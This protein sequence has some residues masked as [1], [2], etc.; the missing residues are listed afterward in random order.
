MTT[1][2]LYKHVRSDACSPRAFLPPWLARHCP[3][4]SPDC[5]HKKN[6]SSNKQPPQPPSPCLPPHTISLSTAGFLSF[7]PHR[8][9]QRIFCVALLLGFLF[10]SSPRLPLQLFLSLLTCFASLL[11]LSSPPTS[12]F[13]SLYHQ[14]SASCALCV[15]RA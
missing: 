5:L 13:F 6:P 14:R 8:Y 7:F 1:F 15:P 9:S 11:S 10:P 2:Q 3:Q 12:C 4:S